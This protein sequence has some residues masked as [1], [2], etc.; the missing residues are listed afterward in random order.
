MFI[1]R[2]WF[3]TDEEGKHVIFLIT[4]GY[5]QTQYIPMHQLNERVNF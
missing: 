3:F 1:Y 5:I 2:V 4:Y